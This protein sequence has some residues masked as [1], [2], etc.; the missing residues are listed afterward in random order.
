MPLQKEYKVSLI[1]AGEL[2]DTLH[3]G[4]YARDWWLVRLTN[5]SNT[6]NTLFYSICLGMKTLTTINNCDFIITVVQGNTKDITDPDYNELQPG[7][8]CQSEGLRS[9]ICKSSS[10]A[11]TSVYQKAFSTK[12]K[13]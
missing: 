3:F 12:T 2:V 13:H 6:L 1:F 8:I 10:Q 4:S 7:Y 9:D 5:D 11:I